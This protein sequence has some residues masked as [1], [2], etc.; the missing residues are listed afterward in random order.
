METAEDRHQLFEIRLSKLQ[1]VSKSCFDNSVKIS[2]ARALTASISGMPFD[3]AVGAKLF[4]PS[5]RA[6]LDRLLDVT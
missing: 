6:R 3:F 4:I 5:V 1:G 2:E